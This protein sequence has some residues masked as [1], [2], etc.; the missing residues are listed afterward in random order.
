MLKESQIRTIKEQ[1]AINKN[2]G[3]VKGGLNSF[4]NNDVIKDENG[5]FVGSTKSVN[6][7]DKEEEKL[8]D[9]K[10]IC[11][12]YL[13]KPTFTIKE[14]SNYFCDLNMY[15]EDYVYDCLTN[16]RVANVM[17]KE[18]AKK[19]REQ[20]ERNRYRSEERR[21]GKECGTFCRSRGGAVG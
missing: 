4:K 2:T 3:K 9:I 21:V 11:T 6:P 15:T 14:I 18:A 8:N 13:E 5:K 17:G 16:S 1:L 19:I 7:G 12:F 10:L 20:L